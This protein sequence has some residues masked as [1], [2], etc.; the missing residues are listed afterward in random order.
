MNDSELLRKYEP[1]LR[2][3]KSE[4]FFPM[5]VEPYLEK[6]AIFPS[7]PQ[8]VVGLLTHLN[9]PLIERIGKLQS[10]EYYLRFVN[11][12]LID[13]DIWAWWGVLSVIAGGAGWFMLGWAGIESVIILSLLA[14]L[15]ILVQVSPIRAR[16]FLAALAALFFFALAAAPVW[17]FLRPHEF[18]SIQVEYLVLFP[19]YL[20]LLF[21]VS[22]RMMKFI[23]DYIIPQAPGVVMDLLSN[24]TEP[25]AHKSFRF[26]QDILK[27]DPQPV[28]YGR[29]TQRQDE[30]GN[31]WKSLQYH[32]FYAFNDW[33]LAANGINHHEGDWEMVAVYLKND[34]PYAV[35]FSQHGSGALEKWENVLRVK[36]NN[37]KDTTHPIIYTALGSHANYSKPQV[38]RSPH[39]YHEGLV[40]RFIYWIDGLIH[41]LFLLINPSEKARQIALHELATHPATALTE[42]TFAKLRDE[43]DHYIVSLPMEIATGDGFRIGCEGDLRHEPIGM[44]SSYLKRDKSDREVIHPAS[45]Q[46]RQVL[47]DPEPGWIQYQGL[48]GVKSTLWDESGPPGPKWDRPDKLFEIAPRK[49]WD[50]E[51]EW[52]MELENLRTPKHKKKTKKKSG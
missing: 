51:L 21:Y 49:R 14:A 27:K 11:D 29:V 25:V 31:I 30:D 22:V 8:G 26:Y 28:Y 7:G 43:R 6:C 33:R 20:I 46:W 12:P 39:L 1:V 40:Q 23:F 52:L 19:L 5:A 9:D 50:R 48:W 4:R 42:E 15:V 35:L 37:G 3:V 18:I 38:I 45:N 24:A 32:F 16:F 47:L 10:G 41:F 36:G 13:S 34:E 2:F 17:F 44:S